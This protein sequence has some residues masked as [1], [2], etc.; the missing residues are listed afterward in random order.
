MPGPNPSIVINLSDRQYQLLEQ[1]ARSKTNSYRLLQ[2]VKLVLFAAAGM[3]NTEISEQLQ[4]SRK[5]VRQWRQRWGESTRRLEIAESEGVSE[6]ELK[7]QIEGVLSDEQRPGGPAKFSL[8]QI[9]QVVAVACEQP[10]SSNRPISHW[11]PRELALEVV[12]RGIV[13]EISP[14]SV[15]RFL[16]RGNAATLVIVIGSMLNLAIK[17]NSNSK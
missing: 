3:N 17:M 12:K 8:E 16:K 9:V 4:L 1:I 7:Q 6:R 14:R 10:Q 13:Q 5:Q 15:A 2:R 11:T